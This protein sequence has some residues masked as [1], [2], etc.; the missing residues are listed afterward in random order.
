[1]RF[2]INGNENDIREIVIK[3]W[4]GTGYGPDV[5]GDMET[6][7]PLDHNR[8]DG[9]DAYICTEEE[10]TELLSWWREYCED[11]NDH[12]ICDN[13]DDWSEYDGPEL[14]IFELGPSRD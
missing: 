12:R 5:F 4:D 7:F 14:E 11:A 3:T 8:L 9:D 10:Y 13:L 6:N 1:M 2:A